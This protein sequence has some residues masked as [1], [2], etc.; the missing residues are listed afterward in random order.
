MIYIGN[1]THYNSLAHYGVQ[2]MK[3]G[4]RKNRLGLA[5]YRRTIQQNYGTAY[6]H[7]GKGL[8]NLSGRSRSKVVRGIGDVAG[9]YLERSGNNLQRYSRMGTGRQ[10]I[11]GTKDIVRN[12]INLAKDIVNVSKGKS[13]SGPTGYFNEA[14]GKRKKKNLYKGD[15]GYVKGLHT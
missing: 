3:W 5:S 10:L 9:S 13:A 4:V 1:E 2:G 8:R 11:E 7:L 6:R 12:P 15:R 14:E